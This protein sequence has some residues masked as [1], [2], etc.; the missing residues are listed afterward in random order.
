VVTTRISPAHVLWEDLVGI[1]V[2]GSRERVNDC[3]SFHLLHGSTS[4]R[5]VNEKEALRQGFG[6]KTKQIMRSASGPS[7]APA[8][9]LFEDIAGKKASDARET[10]NA[11]FPLHRRHVGTRLPTVKNNDTLRRVLTDKTKL[12]MGPS[13]ATHLNTPAHVLWKDAVGKQSLKFTRHDVRL[14]LF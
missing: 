8:H 13:V 11:F 14:L 10:A 2:R 7:N 5:R 1:K 4:L 3:F 9:V 12:I 6:G